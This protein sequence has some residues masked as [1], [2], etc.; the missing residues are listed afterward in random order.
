MYNDRISFSEMA[1]E[2]DREIMTKGILRLQE[3]QEKLE[4]FRREVALMEKRI[5][6]VRFFFSQAEMQQEG[7]G[8]PWCPKGSDC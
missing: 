2:N 5:V 4:R 7:R 6:A 8:V 1:L 3:K